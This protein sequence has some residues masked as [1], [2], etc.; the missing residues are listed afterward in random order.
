MGWHDWRKWW[1]RGRGWGGGQWPYWAMQDSSRARTVEVTAEAFPLSMARPGDEV[2]VKAI[3]AGQG[4]YYRALSLGIA[5][6]TRLKVIDNPIQYPWSPVIVRIRG[7]EV[8]LGRG[9]AEKILVAKVGEAESE[10]GG[11]T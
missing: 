4:A 5:P 10:G 2:V 11:E 7:V 3:M 9:L 6:G 1:R 8:A